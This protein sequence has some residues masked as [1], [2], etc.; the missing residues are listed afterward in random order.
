MGD[1]EVVEFVMVD[2]A[3]TATGATTPQARWL[4]GQTVAAKPGS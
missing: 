1:A 4:A 3:G 2:E